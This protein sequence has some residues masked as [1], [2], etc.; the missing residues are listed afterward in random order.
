MKYPKILAETMQ[1]LKSKNKMG[2]DLRDLVITD[3]DLIDNLEKGKIQ[4]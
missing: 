3:F 1:W 2:T 4:E